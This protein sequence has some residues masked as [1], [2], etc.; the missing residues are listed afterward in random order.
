MYKTL[1]PIP[2]YTQV[3]QDGSL[4]GQTAF[5]PQG[6]QVEVIRT[7]RWDNA[8]VRYEEGGVTLFG[9]AFADEIEP[10]SPH[11]DIREV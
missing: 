1:I 8:L 7:A 5:I 9:W 4:T 10:I 6:G 3:N 2:A 11:V